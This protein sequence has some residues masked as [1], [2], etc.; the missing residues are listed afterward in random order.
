MNVKR[1][2]KNRIIEGKLDRI[3]IDSTY[4]RA[5]IKAVERRIN[6]EA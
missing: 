3:T 5:M 4:V 6:G 2:A 1:Y